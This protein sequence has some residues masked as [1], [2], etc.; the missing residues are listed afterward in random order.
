MMDNKSLLTLGEIYLSKNLLEPAL[1]VLTRI[2][3]G[4][5]HYLAAS[6]RIIQVHYRMGDFTNVIDH[7]EELL[8]KYG[9]D[10]RSL[11][12]LMRFLGTAYS[13]V[14]NKK[15]AKKYL[16]E[17][18]SFFP[19]N[20]QMVEC[21]KTVSPGSER[22]SINKLYD[23]LPFAGLTPHV[24]FD[25]IAPLLHR[26][27]PVTCCFPDQMD[28]ALFAFSPNTFR[29]AAEMLFARFGIYTAFF[30][31][32]QESV[33]L[34]KLFF[35]LRPTLLQEVSELEELGWREFEESSEE[36]L[37]ALSLMKNEGALLEYPDCCVKQARDLRR[38]GQSIEVE[39]LADLIAEEYACS[40]DGAGRPK[41]EFAYFGFEFYPCQARCAAAEK[42]GKYMFELYEKSDPDFSEIFRHYILKLNYAKIYNV[43][44][45]SYSYFLSTFNSGFGA[46]TEEV[47]D[48]DNEG[49]VTCGD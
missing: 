32:A 41:P 33:G 13:Q 18:L 38:A 5:E 40:T 43:P 6:D 17:S 34:C 44:T 30:R 22:P 7:G 29:M 1:R 48:A 46:A 15:R 37:P 2:S 21:Y 42:I 31:Y 14:G 9:K 24:L 25:C 12:D 45:S 19:T 39:A 35:S 20:K 36:N 27:R 3:K 4:D 16:M 8:R 26:G 47:L 49:G 28:E 23:E 10:A 11:N